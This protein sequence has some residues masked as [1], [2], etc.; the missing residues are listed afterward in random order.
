MTTL[1]HP[2][3]TPGNHLC[4]SIEV[5]DMYLDTIMFGCVSELVEIVLYKYYMN[6]CTSKRRVFYYQLLIPYIAENFIQICQLFV[7]IW[8]FPRQLPIFWPAPFSLLFTFLRLSWGGLINKVMKYTLASRIKLLYTLRII[9]I[10]ASILTF[11]CC[12]SDTFR[13]V[14][15][16][17][18]N[19]CF[20]YYLP[21]LMWSVGIATI[22]CVVVW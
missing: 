9:I 19:N 17:K 11:T 2:C 21:F 6:L 18:Q 13:E 12:L 3:C 16:I 22:V 4:S 10:V 15:I 20:L 8:K 14:W 1:H 5:L 7:G